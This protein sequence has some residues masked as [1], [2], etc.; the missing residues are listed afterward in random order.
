M[1]ND[2]ELLKR[3]LDLSGEC[4]KHSYNMA[5]DIQA[6]A[7]AFE[8]A[9]SKATPPQKSWIKDTYGAEL[10]RIRNTMASISTLR[11][12]HDKIFTKHFMY[13]RVI[14]LPITELF[15]NFIKGI[16]YFSNEV[17]DARPIYHRLYSCG[18][19]EDSH[20]TGNLVC[21]A[22]LDRKELARRRPLIERCYV[23][24]LIYDKLWTKEALFFPAV[25]TQET[26]QDTGHMFRLDLTKKDFE[27]CFPNTELSVQIDYDDN[28]PTTLV[29][30]KNIGNE[31]TEIRYKKNINITGY[32]HRIYEDL[33]ECRKE[34]KNGSNTTRYFKMSTFDRA[35]RF[36]QVI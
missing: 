14:P 15:E 21:T 30:K 1:V 20:R 2:E 16:T 3:L 22:G 35:G 23:E 8:K 25:G 29:L 7:T 5:C 31:T 19:H 34:V 28:M 6:A 36:A 32:G 11:S 24:R 26:S 9:A 18:P 12:L 10:L 27:T 33:V 17:S 13:K 4:R